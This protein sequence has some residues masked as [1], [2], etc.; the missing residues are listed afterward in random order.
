MISKDRVSTRAIQNALKRG[1]AGLPMRWPWLVR[2][3]NRSCV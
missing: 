2:N 1:S 3:V